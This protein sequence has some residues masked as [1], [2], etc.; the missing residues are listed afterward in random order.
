MKPIDRD[1]Y[2]SWSDAAR[3]AVAACAGPGSPLLAEMIAARR[4]I[5]ASFETDPSYYLTQLG[6]NLRRELSVIRKC[7]DAVGGGEA[8]PPEA[9]RPSA[10]PSSTDGPVRPP[11]SVPPKPTPRSESRSVRRPRSGILVVGPEGTKAAQTVLAA[12]EGHGA[13]AARLLEARGA[14]GDLLGAEAEAICGIVVLSAGVPPSLDAAF[15]LGLL[16]GLLSLERVCVVHDD[17]ADLPF[18]EAGVLHVSLQD[19]DGWRPKVLERFGLGGGG[20]PHD[21][22]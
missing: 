12:L 11:A 14:P 17:E 9:R 16:I 6:A 21:L 4:R 8:A 2:A 10:R 1:A 7:L 19:P 18:R 5:S 15:S 13:R 22:A 3:E 20:R